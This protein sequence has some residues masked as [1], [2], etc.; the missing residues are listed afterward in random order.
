[1]CFILTLL[2]IIF[3]LVGVGVIIYLAKL[4]YKET[5][6]TCK[7]IERLLNKDKEM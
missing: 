7:E 2:Y 4:S 1:M 5:K 3:G 6:E